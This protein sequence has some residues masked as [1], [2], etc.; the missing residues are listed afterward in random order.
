MGQGPW[1]HGEPGNSVSKGNPQ[2][3]HHPEKRPSGSWKTALRE[4]AGIKPCRYL[5]KWA[6]C[7]NGPWAQTGSGPGGECGW[8]PMGPAAWALHMAHGPWAHGPFIWRGHGPPQSLLGKGMGIPSF[9]E[10]EDRIGK[11]ARRTTLSSHPFEKKKVTTLNTYR[12]IVK[13]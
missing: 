11:F 2:E 3:K 4:S 9:C 8:G 13:T 5:P 10:E 1:T 7:P 12:I 6:L